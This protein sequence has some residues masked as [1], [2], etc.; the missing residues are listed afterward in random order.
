MYLLPTPAHFKTFDDKLFVLSYQAYIVLDPE[1]SQRNYRQAVILQEKIRKILG[2]QLHITSGKPRKGDIFL[3][4]CKEDEQDTKPDFYRVQVS[5]QGITLQSCEQSLIWAIRTLEQILKQSGASLPCLQVEDFAALAFRGFYH[6]VTRGRVPTLAFLKELADK[7]SEY[8]INQLQLYIENTHLFR[9]FS[10]VWR[11]DDPLTPEEI[12]E[13]DNYCYDRGIELVP[14]ISTFSHLYKV[15][16]TKQ[17]CSM[18]ELEDSDKDPFDAWDKQDHHTLDITNQ[19]SFPFICRMIDEYRPLFRT[20]KFNLCADETFDLGFG[21]SK[22]YCDKIGKDK[23]YIE[24]VKKLCN[25]ILEL[26]CK[27]MMWGDIIGK[28]PE[29]VKELPA[30]MVYLNWDYSPNVK[31]DETRKFAQANAVFCNCPGVI[32]WSRLVPDSKNAYK[33]IRKMAEYAYRYHAVGLLNT[34]WGDFHHICHPKFSLAGT[35]CGA[36]FSWSREILEYD[37]LNRQISILEFGKDCEQLSSL[38]GEIS[39]HILYNWM[40]I[41]AFREYEIYHKA[42]QNQ[43][44]KRFVD[45]KFSDA[46]LIDQVK[47]CNASL[48]QIQQEL[49][50]KLP[51]TFGDTKELL[52]AYI[53]VLDACCYLNQVGAIVTQ[54]E[55]LHQQPDKNCAAALATHLEEWLYY[56]K[57]LWRSVSKESE[58]FHIVEIICWYADYLRTL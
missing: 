39:N 44:V 25:H 35:I 5:E 34:D 40:S 33:N 29:L 14:S 3:C 8:K 9:D 27:P 17:F 56:Y 48:A 43:D 11:D 23:A 13:L 37:E 2:F 52:N 21:R 15:L 42:K 19:N 30:E 16:R 57:K 20:D 41:C 7:L 26:G 28:Y 51:Q 1:C 4:L 54:K 47:S 6:D 32:S 38:M 58:L 49:L 31:E 10:E 46:T 36:Q 18:C 45:A 55:Y 12:I 50:H 22:A 53:V 24:F